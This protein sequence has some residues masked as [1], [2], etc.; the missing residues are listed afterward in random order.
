MVGRWGRTE[1]RVFKLRRG[2]KTPMWNAE[3]WEEKLEVDPRSQGTG[4]T[5]EEAGAVRIKDLDAFMQYMENTYKAVDD[6]LAGLNDEDLVPI[7]D[8]RAMGKQ[9]LFEVI[10]G[11]L[12][13]HGAGH[14]GEIWYIKGLQGL[15]GSP[16]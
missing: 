15:E 2:E 14:L 12:L 11:L 5:A 8:L 4:M 3:G 16:V 13:R 6:Y 1:D 9:S 7:R 10:T